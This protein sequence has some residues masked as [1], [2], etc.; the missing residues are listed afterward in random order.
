[1]SQLTKTQRAEI[2]RMQ[3]PARKIADIYQVPVGVVKRIRRMPQQ[4]RGRPLALS[5]AQAQAAARRYLKGESGVALAAEYGVSH[6]CMMMTLRRV[7]VEIR[8]Q[9]R[10][11]A[12]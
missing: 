1:M 10:R 4:W 8:P 12:S 6:R 7:G 5:P 9:G 2:Q 11:C 3:I